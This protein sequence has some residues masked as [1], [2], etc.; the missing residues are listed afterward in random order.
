MRTFRLSLI[1]GVIATAL[2]AVAPVAEAT[3]YGKVCVTK[4]RNAPSPYSSDPLV[5]V[6]A[7]VNTRD[8]TGGNDVEG[9]GLVQSG[10]GA[11]VRVQFDWVHLKKD[12][13]TI[14]TTGSPSNLLEFGES[15]STN[16]YRCDGGGWFA[17]HHDYRTVL[18]FRVWWGNAYDTPWGAYDTLGSDTKSWSCG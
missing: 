3:H 9:L 14:R 5:T 2:V 1:L 6:C 15:Y 7:I 8:V 13:T 4:T 18:R 12:R 11:A 17:G 16:W 10:S